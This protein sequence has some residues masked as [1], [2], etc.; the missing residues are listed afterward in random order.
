VTSPLPHTFIVAGFLTL[1]ATGALFASFGALFPGLQE[2]FEL[3]ESEV[4]VLVTTTSVGGILGSIIIGLV[5]A[6]LSFRTR[7][8]SGGLL[9][10][11]GV[12]ALAL[13]PSWWMILLSGFIT[14]MGTSILTV[15]VNGSFAKGFGR[16]SAAMVSLGGAVFSIGAILGPSV[17]S[18]NPGEPRLLFFSVALV[19]ALTLLVFVI[20]SFPSPLD[21]R[22]PEEAR[23]LPF[24]LLALFIGI[25][26]MQTSV[27]IIITS[28]A[29]T[30]IARQGFELE[31]A[32]RAIAAFWGMVTVARFLAVP[33]SLR[34]KPPVMIAT[35][36]AL[37]FL[38]GLMAQLPGLTMPAYI[39]MGFSM[40]SLFPLLIAWMGQRMPHAKGATAFALTGASVGAALFPPIGGRLIELTSVSSI[41]T[42]IVVLTAVGFIAVMILQNVRTR[43]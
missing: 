5:E 6:L 10:T 30:H 9:A 4:G 19:F 21:I 24:T 20:T 25:F 41:P 13:S 17:V 27:E 28:W 15:E 36:F 29:A 18:F 35:G 16:R 40:G 23:G 8:L 3:S 31:T 38:F 22:E 32:A 37:T 11:L 33:I 14:G 39:L 42:L 2:R 1:L 26:L 34:V 12:T 7:V 43:A